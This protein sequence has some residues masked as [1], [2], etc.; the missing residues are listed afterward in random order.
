MGYHFIITFYYSARTAHSG[1]SFLVG[2]VVQCHP[3]AICLWL[4]GV[5]LYILW[6]MHVVV[7]ET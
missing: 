1:M 6:Q 5:M 2:T 3:V 4:A 7:V